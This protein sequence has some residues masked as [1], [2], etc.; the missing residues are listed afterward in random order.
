MARRYRARVFSFAND[1]PSELPSDYQIGAPNISNEVV[2]LILKELRR[3]PD[4]WFVAL[5]T[6]TGQRLSLRQMAIST[7]NAE[8]G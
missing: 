8:L 1:R 2:A 6:I 3:R 5:E 4:Y 7:M